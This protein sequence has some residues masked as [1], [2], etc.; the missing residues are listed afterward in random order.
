MAKISHTKI[1]QPSL[2]EKR[3]KVT[4]TKISRFTV[5]NIILYCFSVKGIEEFCVTFKGTYGCS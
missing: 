1:K 5:I 3:P 2:G 4:Y